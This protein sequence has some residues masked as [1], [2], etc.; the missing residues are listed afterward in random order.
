MKQKENHSWFSAVSVSLTVLVVAALAVTG[1]VLY[2]RHNTRNAKN[3]AATSPTQTT[4]QPQSTVTQSAQPN[5]SQG[6]NTYNDTGYPA[7]SGISIKYSPEWEINIPG[8]K[9]IGNTK[10]PT[11][12]INERVVFLPSSE[13]PKEEWNTCA[14]NVSA[15]ACGAAPG[16]KTLSSKEFT[17]N[18][19]AAYTATMQNSNRTYHVTVIQGNK[20]TPPAGRPYVEFT[21]TSSDPAAL[22]TYGATMASATFPN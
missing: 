10:N 9:K 5:P 4:T 3:S 19:L 12:V 14:T 22:N 13:T 21:V 2:Q 11:A 15:D 17:I 7:A 6:W 1:L 18:G 8:V 16:D 20:S